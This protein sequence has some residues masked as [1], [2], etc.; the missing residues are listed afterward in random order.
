MGDHKSRGWNRGSCVLDIMSDPSLHLQQWSRWIGGLWAV[1][2]ITSALVFPRPGGWTIDDGVKQ[3]AATQA[4]GIWAER[5]PDGPVRA[6]GEDPEAFPALH[7]PF[8]ARADDG[9]VMGFSPLTRA[10]FHVFGSH[11]VMLRATLALTAVGVWLCCESAGLPLGFLLLPLTFYGLVP[12][13]HALSW[14]LLWPLVW[15]TLGREKVGTSGLLLSGICAGTASLLRPES[16]VLIAGVM[17]YLLWKRRVSPA[18]FAVVGVAAALAVF[19]VLHGLTA[20]QSLFTQVHLNASGGLAH[21]WSGRAEAVYE[22]L[23]GMDSAPLLS[24]GLL[25]LMMGAATVIGYGERDAK[26]PLIYAGVAL[27]MI[28]TVGYQYRLWTHPLPPLALLGANSLLTALPWILVLLRPPFRGRPAFMI[29]LA[30]AGSVLLLTPVSEGVHWGPR[31]LLFAM[32][33]L[34]IDLYRT[35]R[36]HGWMFGALLAVTVVQTLA[37]G[38]LVYA[39]AR[40][41]ADR[42]QRVEAKLGG[43]VIC[44]TMSQCVDLA[45]LWKG[46]EFFTAANPR[47]LRQLLMQ[48][49]E[50]GVD[51]CWLHLEAH[52]RLYVDAFPDAKPVWPHRMTVLNA[53]SLYKT[54]WRVYELVVNAQDS[55]WTGILQAEAGA[56]LREDSTDRALRFQR[57]VVTLA[58]SSAQA[59]HNL[60]LILSR[61]G[62]INEAR[63]EVGRALELDSTLR[64]A[65]QLEAALLSQSGSTP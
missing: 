23:L 5:V 52:D 17:G 64:E 62:M 54:Q 44:P 45:P 53:G 59:H 16:G 24:T 47:E 3:I 7:A 35:K 19:C 27:L 25:V 4:T 20:T 65:R 28:W 34:V 6:Q 43:V 56:L 18:F 40:E 33:L 31:L 32:P 49:R 50:Q 30:V 63:T 21:W 14:L 8:A 12:W 42:Q 38:V 61:A 39:R 48:F 9:Y 37:S 55:A 11:G 1:A 22:L 57:E 13:E 46:R 36:A 41:L 29:S 58:P 51:T 60:A 10:I 15:L 26:K 2:F